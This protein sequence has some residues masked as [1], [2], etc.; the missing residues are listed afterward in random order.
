M[1]PTGTATARPKLD[2]TG[3]CALADREW[4]ACHLYDPA[5]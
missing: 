3:E 4:L 2:K 1:K 5:R